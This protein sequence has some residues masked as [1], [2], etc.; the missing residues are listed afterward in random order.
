[1]TISIH[2]VPLFDGSVKITG[3]N[4]H[5]RTV[6]VRMGLPVNGNL[7]AG[8][9]EKVEAATDG[10]EPRINQIAAKLETMAI[11]MERYNFT[12]E[13]YNRLFPRGAVDTPMGK[14]RLGK[15]QFEKLKNKERTDLMGAMYQTLS[16]PVVILSEEKEGQSSLLYIKSFKVAGSDKIDRVM[17]VVVRIGKDMVAI[18]TGKR[19]KKQIENKI[20]MA[21]SPLYLKGEGDGGPTI[22]T[23]N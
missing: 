20:K 6:Y 16:D 7:K 12:R 23:G 9:S 21:G 4:G 11:P 15:N 5:R 1:M 2:N 13:E 19:K 8:K 17:T 3:K 10:N 14:V 22:G 18:S